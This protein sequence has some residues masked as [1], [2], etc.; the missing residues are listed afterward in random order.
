MKY[1]TS[2]FTLFFITVGLAFAQNTNTASGIVFE[3][4][5]GNMLQDPGER[6]IQSVSVSNGRDVVLTDQNGRYELPVD[7]DDILF[8]IKPSGYNLPVDE[9][10]LP[11]FYYIHKPMG[12][13]ELDFSGVEP[14]GELPETVDFGLMKAEEKND[15]K[16]LVFGDPQPY[17]EQEV[18]YFDKDIVSELVGA[19]EYDVGITLGDIVGDDLDLFDPYTKSVAKI[20]I[21]WFNVYGNHDMNFD[22]PTDSLAD[23][24]FERVFGP[25]SYS[26]NQGD[27]HFIILDDVVYPRTDGESGYIGGFTEEQLTFVENNLEHVSKNKLVV[28]AFHIPMFQPPNRR[29][30]RLDDR[31]RLIEMLEE[32]P[33]TL[34]LSAHTHIQHIEFFDEDSN[35]NRLEPHIHYNVG[36]TSGDWWSGVPNEHGIPPTIM[37]DGTP[38]GYAIINFEGNEF[39]LDYKAAGYD[40]S[41]RMSIW[42]PKVVPQNSWHNAE[43]FV[44]YFLGSDKTEVHYRIGNRPWREM[45]KVNEQDPYVSSLRQKWDNSDTILRGKRPSNPIQSTHLWSSRV[46]NNLPLGE[47]TIEVRVIDQFG[48]V[49]REF[50]DRFTYEVVKPI[51]DQ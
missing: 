14:T 22:A 25:A 50:Y 33:H 51:E 29:T 23:E 47:Q 31:N 2:I 44:N 35:W 21:P 34:S 38:N 27:V 39:T 17:T 1:L 13:P 9:R 49:K 26:F 12:S 18:E 19:D 15:F 46:P 11:Q 4:T 7:N 24:T 5:N 28:V 10:N 32:F 37:R 20:G 43:M 8:V 42:G 45:Q 48:K 3:D 30:F 36:T 40:D 16:I 6:G 41:Y